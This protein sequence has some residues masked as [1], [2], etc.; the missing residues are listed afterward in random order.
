ML[1]AERF[2]YFFVN[3]SWKIILGG[4]AIFLLTNASFLVIITWLFFIWNLIFF[5][6]FVQR[7][8]IVCFSPS[9]IQKTTQQSDGICNATSDSQLIC[10]LFKKQPFL[11]GK[12]IRKMYCQQTVLHCSPRCQNV[13]LP[14]WR[15]RIFLLGNVE[16][17]LKKLDLFLFHMSTSGLSL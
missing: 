7:V 8:V 3:E 9:F 1:L 2:D 15:Y 5:E 11:F 10:K 14:K 16:K 17:L 6:T 12:H 4:G 13:L